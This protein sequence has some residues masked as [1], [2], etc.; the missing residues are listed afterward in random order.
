MPKFTTK[1]EKKICRCEDCSKNAAGFRVVNRHTLKKH[2]K[3]AMKTVMTLNNVERKK[4][5]CK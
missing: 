3:M 1:S 4:Y 2:A 5:N